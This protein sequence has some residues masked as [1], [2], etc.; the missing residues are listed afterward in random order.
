MTPRS[1]QSSKLD[2]ILTVYGQELIFTAKAI[3]DNKG[4]GKYDGLPSKR[5]AHKE[6]LALIESTKREA[7]EEFI[8][9]LPDA[10]MWNDVSGIPNPISQTA[11]LSIQ[12]FMTILW[13]EFKKEKKKDLPS[14]QPRE[15]S[16]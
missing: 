6:I 4:E 14:N 5:K 16:K 7:V 1:K 9:S 11:R 13:T 12:D 8:K 3:V 2:E 15:E 10:I